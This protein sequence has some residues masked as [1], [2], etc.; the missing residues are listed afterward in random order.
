MSTD[1]TNTA[2]QDTA[3]MALYQQ[4]PA[5]QTP[6][7]WF[8][9]EHVAAMPLPAVRADWRSFSNRCD[10]AAQLSAAAYPVE[11]GDFV[12]P[13][14][15][16]PPST[17][18]YRVSKEK[19]L[20]H[21]LINQ[22][23]AVLGVGGSLLL[24]GHKNDGLHSYAKKA[25]ALVGATAEIKKHGG[26]AYIATITK[27]NEPSGTL[28][29]SDYTQIQEIAQSPSLY[30]KPGV[31]GWQKIDRGSALLV[32][33]LPVFLAG[34]K[35]PPT[36]LVDLGC[37]YGFIAVMAAAQ[38]PE[39]R[40]L[41]TDNNA[42]AL[43]AARKNCEVNG[44]SAEIELADCA[45][46]LKGPFAAVLCNPPFHKG[47]AVAGSLTDQ[48][49][50]AAHRL[51]GRNGRA[52]FVVNQFIPLERKAAASFAKAEVLIEVDGFKVVCLSK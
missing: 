24:A 19:A 23:L 11:L 17:V 20:V 36:S 30:S 47:F 39:S 31:F 9:D 21:Y 3:L 7:W 43:L 6:L 52:L 27:R 32:E 10:I 18:C 4:F 26:A 15:A 49:I 37:G 8:A 41:L 2:T 13:S 51:L 33:Q 46:G 48:F 28:A 1:Q 29:D 14:D 5:V 38:L 35:Q 50:A 12:M 44:I 25:A 16:P 22:A 34:F 45:A 42:T 40:W